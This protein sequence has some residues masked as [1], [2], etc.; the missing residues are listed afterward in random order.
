[1]VDKKFKLPTEAQ[2]LQEYFWQLEK[3]MPN[4][5]TNWAANAKECKYLKLL[6]E[7]NKIAN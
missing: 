2:R 6:K 1:M 3:I 5:P 4:P 7:R